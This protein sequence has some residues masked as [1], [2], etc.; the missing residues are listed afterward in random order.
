MCCKETLGEVCYLD[1]PDDLAV[2][3]S[4]KLDLHL[5]DEVKEKES[6]SME[7]EDEEDGKDEANEDSRKDV[8]E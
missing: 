1:V 6:N 3:L 7:Q 2:A 8:K 5:R 4:D